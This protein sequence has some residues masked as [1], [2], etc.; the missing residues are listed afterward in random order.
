MP[1]SR[2][3]QATIAFSILVASAS[4]SNAGPNNVIYGNYWDD[5]G[6]EATFT[7]RGGDTACIINFTQVAAN[8]LLLLKHVACMA[9]TTGA[10]IMDADIY[11][12][13]AGG[14]A[15]LTRNHPLAIPQPVVFNGNG[16]SSNINQDVNILVGQYR[17]PGIRLFVGVN[18]GAGSWS[19]KCQMS[20]TL[21]DPIP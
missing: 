10:P 11:I 19:V 8:K 4:Q 17:I 7:C 9:R 2:F 12:S 16:Y 20:G 15:P 13:A 21:V 5:I 1:V 6:V 3:T 14:G 18:A